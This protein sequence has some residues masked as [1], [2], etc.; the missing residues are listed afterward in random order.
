[1]TELHSYRHSLTGKIEKLTADAAGEFPEYLEPVAD[2]AKPYE[3]GLFKPGK[4]GEFKNPE[5]LTDEQLT[6]RA[7]LDAIAEETGSKRTRAAREAAAAVK[8][9]DQ[10]AEQAQ[11]EINSETEGN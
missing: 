3:P 5:P 9:A 11:A 2:D 6:A 8:E 4:V 1:M 7:Q 10:A